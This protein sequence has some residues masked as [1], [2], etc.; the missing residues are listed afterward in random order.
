MKIGISGC[1][2]SARH[3]GNPWHHYMGL[4]FNA[5]IVESSSPGAGN[6]MNF[7]KVKYILDTHSDLDLF[8]FQIT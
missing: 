6:E 3:W 5:E 1:S 8:V 4:R 7:E 2:H